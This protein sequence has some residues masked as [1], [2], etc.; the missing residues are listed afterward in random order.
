MKKK[1]LSFYCIILLLICQ[2]FISLTSVSAISESR[3]ERIANRCDVIHDNLKEL[4]RNDSKV[5]I[6]LGRYYDTI[7]TGFM[8][9][10]S[11]WLEEN[12]FSGS[13]GLLSNQDNFYQTQVDFRDDYI[14]YQKELEILGLMDCKAEPEA[15]YDKLV[16]VREKRKIV[17]EDVAKLRKIATRQ[18][19]L[20]RDLEAEL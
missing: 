18:I 14:E 6:N 20:V 17:T 10:L 3:K 9:P 8:M 19:K 12:S 16:E 2:C 5:R 11:N 4:Q 7:L 1:G 13:T 15:F